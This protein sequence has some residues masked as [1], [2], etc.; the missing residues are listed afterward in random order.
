[1]PLDSDVFPVFP[2]QY[3][4]TLNV[5]PLSSGDKRPSHGSSSRSA[6]FFSSRRRDTHNSLENVV[7]FRNFSLV[8]DSVPL[9][10]M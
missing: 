1:M 3:R 5:R 8:R 9:S 7:L 6:R 4:S 10:F 2:L